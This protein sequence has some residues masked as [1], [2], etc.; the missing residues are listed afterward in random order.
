[1]PNP[2][3]ASSSSGDEAHV[4][5]ERSLYLQGY[6]HIAG[7]DEAGR[8]PLAGPVVAGCVIFPPDTLSHHLL[9]Y[10]DSKK[11][12][13]KQ[14]ERLY[15][16]LEESPAWLG[17]GLASAEE[18]DTINI[19]QAS[20]LAM[21]RAVENC[22]KQ[23]DFLLVDGCFQVPMTCPQRTLVQGES[24]SSS[25]AAASI[26]AKVIRDR[27]MA[28]YHTRYPQ[29]NFLQHKGYPTQAHRAALAQY[30]P[31]PIHRSTFKG[32]RDQ[33]YEG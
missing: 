12:T 11:L 9:V 15:T 28:A 27:L 21:R 6:T 2:V 16:S 13:A 26:V 29:Y 8:G 24:K 3:S 22:P 23:A 32:V 33:G 30:G 14:R 17:W 20:L 19:L 31:C 25:I 4:S 7:I 18:I 10:K 1:M 5:H